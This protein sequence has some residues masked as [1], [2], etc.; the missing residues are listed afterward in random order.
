M[1]KSSI[2]HLH[3]AKQA[4]EIEIDHLQQP[5]GKQDQYSTAIGGLKHILFAQDGSVEVENLPMDNFLRKQISKEFSLVWTGQHRNA[6]EILKEQDSKISSQNS[7]DRLLRM[8]EQAIEVRDAFISHDL[9][10]VGELL[11]EGWQ[12]KKGLSSSISNPA[13]DELYGVIMSCGATGCKLLGAGGGG[14]IL[15]HGSE[16]VR[17]TLL[18]QNPEL[19]IIPLIPDISGTTLL[20]GEIND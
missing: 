8:R 17:K 3:L 16:N 19:K 15:F 14:F 13:I 12:L 9:A 1:K 11:D 7:Q 5:I 20:A 18:K 2:N 10:R 6:A 4:C